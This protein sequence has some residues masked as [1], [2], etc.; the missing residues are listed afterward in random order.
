MESPNGCS[1]CDVHFKEAAV[2]LA[3]T[4]VSR[5]KL[6]GTPGGNN[7]IKL[8]LEMSKEFGKY[9][10]H[11]SCTHLKSHLGSTRFLVKS[12]K[13]EMALIF[14]SSLVTDNEMLG[15]KFQVNKFNF[16]FH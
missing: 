7:N 8:Y 1:T 10:L 16:K 2:Q 12:F 13:E 14:S 4:S 9:T 3:C 15:N 6:L 11:I 5:W